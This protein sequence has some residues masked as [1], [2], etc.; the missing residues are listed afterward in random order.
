MEK[1]KFIIPGIAEQYRVNKT[2]ILAMEKF[3]HW[4][5]DDIEISSVYGMFP[6]SL[7]NAG[8]IFNI[9]KAAYHEDI[10]E[11]KEFYNSRDIALRLTYTN[12]LIQEEHL[13]DRFCN[14]IMESLHN[15]KNEVVLASNI[16]ENYLR[17][18]YPNFKYCSSTTKTLTKIDDLLTE[19]E[20]PYYQVCLDYNLNNKFN[21]LEKIPV[22]QRDKC[23][24]LVN[25]ICPPGCP[26][27]AEHY[28]YNSKS[29]L[30]HGG[31]F[32]IECGITHNIN[33][34]EAKQMGHRISHQ[35]IVNKYLPLGFTHFKLEGRT[36]PRHDLIGMYADYFVKPE[37][38]LDF[39]GVMELD[40]E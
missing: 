13:N 39:I 11:I 38:I 34:A 14:M 17:T 4:F 2:L 35:D 32:N 19:L 22:E 37:H 28:N 1:A 3:P 27:R 5:Y 18:T 31:F 12:L 15:G 7:W 25:A 20:S 29:M 16:L 36:L 24:F 23:E 40:C 33:S 30:N 21:Q 6:V 26:H 10:E 8:R 9:Y